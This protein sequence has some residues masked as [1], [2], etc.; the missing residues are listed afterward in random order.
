MASYVQLSPIESKGLFDIALVDA[1]I[2]VLKD[3]LVPVRVEDI[4]GWV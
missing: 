3:E 4:F 2:A 1:S